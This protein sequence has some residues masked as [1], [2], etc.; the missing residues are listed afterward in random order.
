MFED[1][2]TQAKDIIRRLE[3]H[4]GLSSE[5]FA[6]LPESEKVRNEEG[7][8][9]RRSAEYGI[10]Q[11]F[12]ADSTELGQWNGITEE[13]FRRKVYGPEG[14]IWLY[15]AQLAVL[16]ELDSKLKMNRHLQGSRQPPEMPN[17]DPMHRTHRNGAANGATFKHVVLLVHGIN[18]R[19]KWVTAIKPTLEKAGL[20][21]APCG[22]D[23]YGVLRFLL[24]F[25]WLRRKAIERVRTRMNTAIELHKPQQLSVIAH[26]FGSYIVAR[27][28]AQ[29]FQ[30]HWHRIIFCGS[31]NA[32]DFPFEQY[33][34]R[35]VPPIVN[36]IGSRDVLPAFAERVTW[37]YGSIGSH[38]A[39]SAAIEERW[40][41]G[42]GHS[43]FLNP[44]FCE[45]FWIPWLSDGTFV[46]GDAAPESLPLWA[47]AMVALPLRWILIA[48]LA[49]LGVFGV[50]RLGVVV[51][52]PRPAY[53][54]RYSE[55]VS[56][57]APL[58][59]L[60]ATIGQATSD[61]ASNCTLGW[62]SRW[63][64][65]QTC[66]ATQIDPGVASLRACESF[67]YPVLTPED[68]LRRAAAQFRCLEVKE[69]SGTMSLSV[70]PGST[71][72]WDDRGMSWALCGCSADQVGA[73][74][75]NNR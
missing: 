27:L 8:A 28:L 75:R 65:G 34:A 49:T 54:F 39:L 37:G 46:R 18:T 42:L 50:Q 36:E 40:H 68:A 31:V 17:S 20:I 29:E 9:W 5:Q 51:S 14:Y 47:R 41:N 53:N 58:S 55:H 11:A 66:I 22:Y 48:L 59:D 26:S 52:G 63:K 72:Q 73:L 38:G 1:N 71:E 70:R 2:V 25:D 12:G 10:R 61:M 6:A 19:A 21:G 23:V 15:A 44:A 7:E 3:K 13:F 62:F 64:Y 74:R 56:A 30:Q 67:E 69:T 60:G 4:V 24:P 57:T 45:K 32:Q 33:L 43:D 35:F 16:Q